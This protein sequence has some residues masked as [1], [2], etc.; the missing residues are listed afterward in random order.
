MKLFSY[1]NEVKFCTA[2]ILNLFSNI[3]IV[4]FTPDGVEDYTILVPCIYGNRSRLLKSLENK[5][6]TLKLPFTC[7]SLT[8]MKRSIERVHDPHYSLQ[9]SNSTVNPL[10]NIGVPYDLSYSF[11]V[12]AKFQEDVDQILSNFL[13]HFNPDLFVV[14]PHPFKTGNIRSQVVYDDNV[15]FNYPE[16]ENQTK[17]YRITVEINLTYKSWLFPG[18]SD[19]NRIEPAG[20]ISGINLSGYSDDLNRY[21]SIP[22]NVEFDTYKDNILSGFIDVNKSS[23]LIPIYSDKCWFYLT[24]ANNFFLID[25]SEQFYLI[26]EDDIYLIKE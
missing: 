8:S 15:V 18:R 19:G 16:D 20:I 6:A 10:Y 2:Q 7:L 25:E 12:V 4:R 14:W 22:S 26:T 3:P 9:F 1:N 23:D 13:V 11:S 5:D 21:Y 24:S 17:Q